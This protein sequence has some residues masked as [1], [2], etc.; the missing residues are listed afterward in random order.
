MTYIYKAQ[1]YVLI[2]LKRVDIP[3]FFIDLLN[4]L[5]SAF[6]VSVFQYSYT[7]SEH[8]YSL[9]FLDYK[10]IC[11]GIQRL[12]LTECI[13]SFT[14][15]S[16]YISASNV[17]RQ[18]VYSHQRFGTSRG[19]NVDHIKNDYQTWHVPV[20]IQYDLLVRYTHILKDT[21]DIFFVSHNS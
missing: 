7:H 10:Y 12:E 5:F 14:K 13:N 19:R 3:T 11:F 20:G 2:L 4:I 18:H 1:F 16:S 17:E 9:K 21:R 8:R 15:N 6:C